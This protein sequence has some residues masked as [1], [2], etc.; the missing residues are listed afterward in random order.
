[1]H[2][3]TFQAFK[4]TECCRKR[5][6]IFV[7]SSVQ[8][9]PCF[10]SIDNKEPEHNQPRPGV[11][12]NTLPFTVFRSSLQIEKRGGGS[13]CSAARWI[14]SDKKSTKT[15]SRF[16]QHSISKSIK[17]HPKNS[18]I[19]QQS[20]LN[21]SK[22]YQNRSKIDR[23]PIWEPF[24]SQERFRTDFAWIWSASCGPRGPNLTPT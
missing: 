10:C 4:A 5:C 15:R 18:N 12:Q 24:G 1:M 13:R 7:A 23:H 22:I 17:H 6:K 9:C 8:L 21:P 20:I 2:H 19:D 11:N 14:I 16:I 3:I